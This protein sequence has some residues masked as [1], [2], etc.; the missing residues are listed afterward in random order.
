MYTKTY[1]PVGSMAQTL[2]PREVFGPN[3][4]GETGY[5]Y[6]THPD[7]WTIEGE[8][9]EDYYLWVNDFKAHHP[10]FGFVRGNFESVVEATSEEAL[11]HF[12]KNHP[13][14]VWDYWDI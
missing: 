7:G 12:L 10:I 1:V 6:Y 13:I 3:H 14:E 11:E 4:K 8:I 5:N 2:A 9:C